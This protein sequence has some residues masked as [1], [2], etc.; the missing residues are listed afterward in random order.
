M[1]VSFICHG[2]CVC[3]L[4]GDI[5]MFTVVRSVG[6]LLVCDCDGDDIQVR[7]SNCIIVVVAAADVAVVVG[8]SRLYLLSY[9]YCTVVEEFGDV[10]KSPEGDR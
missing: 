8:D 10:F 1:I 4:M 9:R 2:V 7:Y 5:S 6:G 3:V